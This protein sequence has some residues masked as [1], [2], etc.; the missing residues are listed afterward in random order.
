MECNL[1]CNENITDKKF[2]KI[3]ITEDSRSKFLSK[4]MRLIE[5]EILFSGI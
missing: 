5:I 3:F 4:Y 2:F 1:I